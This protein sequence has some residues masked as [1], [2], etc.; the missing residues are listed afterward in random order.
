MGQAKEVIDRAWKIMEDQQWDRIGEVMSPR[1]EFVMPGQVLRGIEEFRGMCN[2]WWA[3][4]P[5]LRHEILDDVESADTY[6]CELAMVGTHTG[7]MRSPNGDIP[8]TGRK[9]R[10]PSADYIKLKDGKIV[11]WHAYPDML[12]MLGQLGVMGK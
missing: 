2:G 3:A 8:A 12:G 10:M 9:I 4:F 5:D 11:S 6:V 1:V 7:T